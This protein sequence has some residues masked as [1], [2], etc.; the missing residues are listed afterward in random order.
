MFYKLGKKFFSLFVNFTRFTQVSLV[1]LSFFI[2]IYWVLEIAGAKFIEPFSP[3]F[4]SI[5]SFIHLFYNR[6]VSVDSVSIDFSFLL[7]TFI[8]LLIAQSL[9]FIAE[10]IESIEKKYDTIYFFVKRKIEEQFNVKLEKEYIA[11]EQKINKFI[12]LIRF[13][14]LNLSKDKFFNKEIDVGVKEKEENVLIDF[15]DNFVTNLKCHKELVNEGLLLYFNNFDDIDKVLFSLEDTITALKEKYAEQQWQISFLAGLEVYARAK[16]V[17][18]KVRKLASLLKLDL[19]D[20]IIGLSTL[21][22]RYSLIASPKYLIQSQG[23]YEIIQN[24]E[25]FY[26]ENLK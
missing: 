16:E 25:V 20:K 19:K 11:Q 22:H 14:A 4:E 3:F 23:S 1:F 9:K 7:A 13:T 12:L 17:S 21:K 8:I 24:E 18:S 15:T 10:F 2:N 26:I 5:K 6:T